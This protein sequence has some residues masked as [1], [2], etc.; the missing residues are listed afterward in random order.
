VTRQTN[1]D[2]DDDDDDDAYNDDNKPFER[3]Q[4]IILTSDCNPQPSE[5]TVQGFIGT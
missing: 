4:A 3:Q 1:D 5:V 2:D